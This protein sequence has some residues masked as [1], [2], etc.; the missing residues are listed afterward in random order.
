MAT[1]DLQLNR[2]YVISG[3]E[4]AATGGPYTVSS[5]GK[6]T[7]DT[8][9]ESAVKT[10]LGS[11]VADSP[12]SVVYPVPFSKVFGAV[13]LS[14]GTKQTLFTVPTG[15]TAIIQ[16]VVLRAASASLATASVG[17]GFDTNASD[18]IASAT[19]TELTGATLETEIPAMDGAKAGAAAAVFGIKATVTQNATVT[20]DVHGYYV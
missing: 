16:R 4:I 7:V 19:H 14:V 17:F 9:N 13:D 12:A 11:L 15:K 18:V 1:V 3:M 5:G 10:D 2:G 20:V 8:T 6:I